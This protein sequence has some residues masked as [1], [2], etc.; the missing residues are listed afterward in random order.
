M[1]FYLEEPTDQEVKYIFN[2]AKNEVKRNVYTTE[3]S[4]YL[5]GYII[6]FKNGKEVETH[7]ERIKTLFEEEKDSAKY[8]HGWLRLEIELTKHNL[9]KKERAMILDFVAEVNASRYY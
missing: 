6:K 1:T 5:I 2:I 7:F 4:D 9:T 8:D 3:Y